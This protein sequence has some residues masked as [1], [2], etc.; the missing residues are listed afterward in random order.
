[1]LRVGEPTV[2]KARRHDSPAGMSAGSE[3][4]SA[5]RFQA[6][7]GL[8]LVHPSLTSCAA[9]LPLLV[10]VHAYGVTRDDP[11][12]QLGAEEAHCSD[13]V[14]PLLEGSTVTA[15]PLL[16]LFTETWGFAEDATTKP[17]LQVWPAT[18]GDGMPQS[19]SRF[20]EDTGENP[21][22]VSL[23]LLAPAL[24]A[25]WSVHEYCE[26]PPSASVHVAPSLQDTFRLPE[27]TAEE[28]AQ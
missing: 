8:K 3:Q 24:P 10:T 7:T 25:F 26:R 20:Q 22:Q 18:R 14:T 21:E 5:F 2:W 1:M 16:K 17:N 6:F 11:E 19:E 23:M 28:D 4:S 12:V 9:S 27:P 15:P 13:S